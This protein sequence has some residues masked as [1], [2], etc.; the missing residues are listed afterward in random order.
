ME[1]LG[2]KFHELI[3]TTPPQDVFEALLQTKQQSQSSSQQS[4]PE[5]TDLAILNTI[6]QCIYSSANSVLGLHYLS[7]LKRDCLH[8]L[9]KGILIDTKITANGS[10]M[11]YELF[12]QFIELLSALAMFSGDGKTT[13]VEVDPPPFVSL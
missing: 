7:S 11:H 10:M 12:D 1:L 9:A 3:Q 4:P 5:D 8:M 6:M 13:V 2:S